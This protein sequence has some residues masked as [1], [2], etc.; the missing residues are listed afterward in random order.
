MSDCEIERSLIESQVIPKVKVE[1]HHIYS[2]H[3][4]SR[5]NL[6]FLDEKTIIFPSGNNCVI[7]NVHKHVAKFIRGLMLYQHEQQGIRALAISPDRRYLA[8]SESGIQS[9]VSVYDLQSEECTSVQILMAN[10]FSIQEFVCM[11][12]SADSKY[13]L[14][15]AGGPEWNLFYWEWEKDKL[16]AIVETTKLGFVNQV[17]FNPVDNTQIC[18][19]GSYVFSV[20]KLENDCLKKISMFTVDCECIKSHAWLSGDSIVLGTK[21]GNLMLV[22]EGMLF[23]L[24]S[25]SERQMGNS[26]TSSTSALLGI[27]VITAYSKGFACAG[28][29][30]EVC[31]YEKTGVYGY[32]KTLVIK[33][34][35][36]P[37]S[38]E[39]SVSAQQEVKSMCLSPSEETLAISTRQGQIY[40]VNLT[41]VENSQSKLANF[42]YLFHLIHSG[43]ITDLSVCFF[44][45]L[46]AT[47]SKD[48]SVHIWNYKTNSLELHQEFPEEPNCISLHPNG[49]SILVG[50]SDKVRLMNLLVDQFRTVQVFDIHNCSKCIFN[51]DGNLFAAVSENLISIINFRTG[52]KVEL[53]GHNGK[54]QSVK[55]RED[56]CQLVS[57][58]LDGTVFEWNALTGARKSLKAQKSFS[59][60][61][62]TFSASNKS[63]ISVGDSMLK[64]F[65]DGE[66]LREMTSVNE[67][68]TSI[69]MTQSG[70]AVFVGTSAGILRVAQYP[71]E[72]DISWMELQAHSGPITNM[73]ITPGDQYLLTASEDGS[74]LAWSITDQDGC[75]LSM[76]KETCFT[77]EEEEAEEEKD[78]EVLCSKAFLEKKDQRVLEVRAQM[79]LLREELD[80]KLNQTHMDYEIKLDKVRECFLKEIDDL[81]GV[82][83]MLN[84]EMEEQ[85]VSQEKVLAETI[86]KHAEEL[87]DQ[88]K[89]FEKNLL[90]S[91]NNRL[92][93]RQKY[94]QKLCEQDKNRFQTSM[95]MKRGYD[96]RLQQEQDKTRYAEEK[97]EELQEKVDSNFKDVL[98]QKDQE[99]QAEKETNERLQDEMKLMEK[100]IMQFWKVKGEIQE[101]CLDLSRL[102]AKVMEINVKDKETI[103]H[104]QQNIKKQEE[105]LCIERKQV[106]NMKALVQR[107]KADIK[108]CSSFVDQ[109]HQLKANFIRL[110]KTYN[111]KPDMR[112]RVKFAVVQESRQKEELQSPTVSLE[113]KQAVES[114]TQQADCCKTLKQ[115]MEFESEEAQKLMNKDSTAELAELCLRYKQELQAELET[116]SQLKYEIKLMEKQMVQFWKIK[117]EIQDQNLEI[118]ML[119][120]EVQSLHD[121]HMDGKKLRKEK[122][123]KKTVQKKEVHFQDIVEMHKMSK[124][125]NEA[126]L[127]RINSQLDEIFKDCNKQMRQTAETN[128]EE[129][130]NRIEE[131]K[132]FLK[133]L[134]SEVKEINSKNQETIHNLKEELKVKD[135]ELCTERQRIKRLK[136][137]LDRMKADIQTC[138]DVIQQPKLLK[139]SILKLHKSYITEAEI[140]AMP[141]EDKNHRGRTRD[142]R[143]T[144]IHAPG[145]TSVRDSLKS[146][147]SSVTL[148]KSPY[149]SSQT[150]K[151]DI[152]K[153]MDLPPINTRNIQ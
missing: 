48:N 70:Q 126:D 141:T 38:S 118:N 68:Y 4:E 30:G 41:S 6:V 99:L 9:T 116:C 133:K 33:I 77:E 122:E 148:S 15:Q 119:K 50:F 73:V 12:F 18:V 53:K 72:E 90:K 108:N 103:E 109:P 102:E 31:I 144:K 140:S 112:F 55:W 83:Q 104:L 105:E 129:V 22:K 115:L 23:S 43:S 65:R 8:V 93:M 139:E 117:E 152:L 127:K 61:D 71:F 131:K 52:G 69:S 149:I 39:P 24:T 1:P 35:Q 44:K 26:D 89:T 27:T 49:L 96:Q 88:R 75:K 7:Y 114:K 98:L 146:G 91:Y 45:P 66:V 145:S 46:F 64:E 101:Q 19:S 34:P 21:T 56:A 37:C 62:M 132:L 54:V 36:D 79:E 86:E 134:K 153:I 137:L 2:L 59:F 136:A 95:D 42:E 40:H 10:G 20:F 60:T 5:N 100:Q 17:S 78:E 138:S 11:A 123:Q 47:C 63:I 3:Q 76:V 107:M 57:N 125:Q 150:P 28:S 81:K 135:N 110:N 80:C 29:L 113:Q 147:R 106:R 85:K 84:T 130:K 14:C 111:H 82:I 67:T 142:S 87:K 74:L 32:T 151:L 16:I 120:E 128:L 94:E 97:L 143:T 13:I 121:Q 124:T 25:P 51:H 92:A 58:G